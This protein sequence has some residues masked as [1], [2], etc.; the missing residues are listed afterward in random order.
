MTYS[1][2]KIILERNKDRLRGKF[3]YNGGVVL[4][5]GDDHKTM[6]LRDAIQYLIKNYKNTECITPNFRKNISMSRTNCDIYIRGT[7]TNVLEIAIIIGL[8]R[9]V[10]TRQELIEWM[11]A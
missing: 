10:I 11:E 5:I 4:D 1:K 6:P 3:E 8:E 7:S 9:G 2:A